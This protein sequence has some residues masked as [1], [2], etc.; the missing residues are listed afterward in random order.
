[1]KTPKPPK[2]TEAEV[3]LQN[4]QREDMARLDEEENLR[5]K[6]GQRSRL[7][8]RAVRSSGSAYLGAAP[9]GRPS[10]SAPGAGGYRVFPSGGDGPQI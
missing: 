7:G 2:P 9:A 10:G 1:M 6:R 5:L 3:Q 8:G 4:R